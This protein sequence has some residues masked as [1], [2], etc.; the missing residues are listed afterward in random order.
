M[1]KTVTVTLASL[2]D[3]EKGFELVKKF[4]SKTA[5]YP[6]CPIDKGK[7]KSLL[8]ESLKDPTSSV[9]L[10]SSYGN[11]FTREFTGILVG[12]ARELS[13]STKRV[14]CELLW[15]SDDSRSLLYLWKTY[16]H[17]AEKIAKVDLLSCGSYTPSVDKYLEHTEGMAPL[18]R[19]FLQ[20]IRS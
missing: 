12:V 15:F 1:A 4:H 5:Y 18:E 10:L 6:L 9:V 17:W 2:N 14:A 19:S 20:A 7:V 16:K 13:F 8:E 3:F 11:E